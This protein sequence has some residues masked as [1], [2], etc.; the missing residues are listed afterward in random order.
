MRP[1]TSP[2]IQ[3]P[4]QISGFQ[5]LPATHSGDELADVL[6]DSPVL[7]DG[8]HLRRHVVTSNPSSV[9]QRTK[10]QFGVAFG[11]FHETLFDGL[12]P[13]G[14]PGGDEPRAHVDAIGAQRQRGHE[15][16]RIAEAARSDH[17]N[18]NMLCS[19]WNQQEPRDVVFSRVPGALETIDRNSVDT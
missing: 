10:D 19:S 7:E 15:S 9:A 1:C 4:C 14:L 11:G 8:H 16:S 12:V 3:I 18:R 5:H 17:S 13:R 2:A 6:E